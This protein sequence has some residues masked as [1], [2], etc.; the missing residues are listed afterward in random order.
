MDENWGGGSCVMDE[1]FEKNL[2]IKDE[3]VG[4]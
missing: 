3:K 1:I 2:H 4:D